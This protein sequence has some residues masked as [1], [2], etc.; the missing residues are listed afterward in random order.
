[1]NLRRKLNTYYQNT[2]GLRGKI[3]K[4]FKNKFRLANYDC[5]AFTETW[6]NDDFFSSELFDDTYNVYRADRTVENYN[7][8][9]VNRPDLPPDENIV[10]GGSLIALRRDIPTMRMHAWENEVPFDNVWLKLSTHGSSKI[11]IHTIYIPAWSST[12]HVN[13]Y[14][15]QLFDIMNVR[16]LYSRFIL[17]GDSNLPC[18]EWFSIGNYCIL[19][20]Y[21]SRLN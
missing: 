6:L 12:E 18:I 16:E 21:D 14:F 13:N 7:I 20:R 19:V 3:V 11:F 17:L 1:M 8:L 5:V 15:E 4:D 9:R 2:R 10:G